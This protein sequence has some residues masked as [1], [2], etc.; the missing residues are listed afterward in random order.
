MEQRVKMTGDMRK[1]HRPWYKKSLSLG[2][3]IQIPRKDRK[4]SYLLRTH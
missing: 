3:P 4:D 1:K 2:H